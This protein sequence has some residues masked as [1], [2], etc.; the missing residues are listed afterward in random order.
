MVNFD[1]KDEFS[2]LKLESIQFNLMKRI[3]DLDKK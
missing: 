3:N 2:L 1:K